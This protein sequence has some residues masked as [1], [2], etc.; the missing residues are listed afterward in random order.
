[1]IQS[2]STTLIIAIACTLQATAQLTLSPMFGDHM[3]LQRELPAPVWGVPNPVACRYA[4]SNMPKVNLVNRAG[5]P[6]APFR[7]DDW[8]RSEAPR[9]LNR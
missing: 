1:M 9:I 8:P 4:F 3:V 5:L 2:R 6:A 7:T